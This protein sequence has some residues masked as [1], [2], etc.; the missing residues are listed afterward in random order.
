MPKSRLCLTFIVLV[1]TPCQP[2]HEMPSYVSIS[3]HR[4]DL[5][6]GTKTHVSLAGGRQS[7]AFLAPRDGRYVPLHCSASRLSPSPADNSVLD[8]LLKQRRGQISYGTDEQHHAVKART[9]AVSQNVLC[10]RTDEWVST[11]F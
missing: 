9:I 11:K 8:F 3:P 4:E 1:L 10:F 7:Q 6:C 2:G 5:T